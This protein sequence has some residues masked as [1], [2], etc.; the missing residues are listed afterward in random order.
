MLQE[1]ESDK[2]SISLIPKSY[3]TMVLNI[4]EVKGNRVT[5]DRDDLMLQLS[6][7]LDLQNKAMNENDFNTWLIAAGHIEAIKDILALFNTNNN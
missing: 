3:Q 1:S 4:Y 5:L 2:N 7:C 6:I